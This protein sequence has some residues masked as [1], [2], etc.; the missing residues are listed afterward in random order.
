[1]YYEKVL[2]KLKMFKQEHLLS[3]YDELTQHDKKQLLKQLDLINYKELL[4]NFNSVERSVA[5][6]SPLPTDKWYDLSV[7]QKNLYYKTGWELL[8]D[9][10]VAVVLLAGGQGTRLSHSG[11]KGT[12]KIGHPITQSLFELQA[13]WLNFFKKKLGYYIPW[14]IMTSQENHNETEAFF[15]D[16]NY[17]NYNRNFIHFFKQDQIP[18]FS[19]DKKILLKNKKEILMVPNGNGGVFKS[20]FEVGHLEQMKEEGIEWIFLNNIDNV[21][22]KVA[23]PKFLGYA[24]IHKQPISSKS[25]LKRSPEEKVGIFCNIN[26]R[27]AVIEYMDMN[28]EIKYARDNSN[29]L[30]YNNANIGIHIFNIDFLLNNINGYLPYHQV[31]KKF[32]TIDSNGNTAVI[33]NGI[34]LELF[35]FDIFRYADGMSVLQVNREEEFAPVK[36]KIGKDSVLDAKNMYLNYQTLLQYQNELYLPNI[37]T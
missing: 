30:V 2:L 35:L 3:F 19:S 12:F 29:N 36:N 32:K 20:L 7:S 23:D 26:N 9:R 17:F 1:M 33:E 5:N 14:Y 21:L 11:P 28:T 37:N 8:K 22:V 16:N 27:P 34:K 13:S 24:A 25:V 18:A 4:S 6:I 10:K 15:Q 31:V